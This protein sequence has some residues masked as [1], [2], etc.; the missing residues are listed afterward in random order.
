MGRQFDGGVDRE[1]AKRRED[2][3]H[4][5]HEGSRR[6][7]YP[8]RLR[9]A[10]WLRDPTIPPPPLS[11]VASD[12]LASDARGA[13]VTRNSPPRTPPSGD[14]SSAVWLLSL[15]S[16]EGTIVPDIERVERLADPQRRSCN[17][18]VHDAYTIA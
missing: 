9:W 10:S 3:K 5:A 4:E 8:S 11:Q 6:D 2:A 1:V 18:A 16:G 14:R 7:G 17:Q 13:T 12:P 15:Q